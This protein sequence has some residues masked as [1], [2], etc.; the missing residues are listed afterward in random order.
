[1]ESQTI[2]SSVLTTGS[3]ASEVSFLFR[4]KRVSEIRSYESKIR[5]EAD[6]KTG[7]LRGLLGTRYRDLLQAADQMTEIR[8]ASTVNVRDALRQAAKSA[9]QLREHFLNQ[10]GD[11]VTSFN[12]VFEDLERRKSVQVIGSKLKFIVDSPEMLYSYL[13]SGDVYDAAKRY[14]LASDSYQQLQKT[15]DLEGIANSFAESRW[16]QVEVFKKQILSAAESKLVTPGMENIDYARYLASLIIMTDTET[17]IIGILNGMFASRTSWVDDDHHENKGDVPF[18]IRN[19]AKTIKTTIS[20]MAYMFWGEDLIME[21]LLHEVDENSVKKIQDLIQ[22]GQLQETSVSWIDSIS[23]WLNDHGKDILSDAKSSRELADTLRAL[24]DIFEGEEWSQNCQDAMNQPP[25][26]VFDLFK[27]YISKRADIVAH[28]CVHGAVNKVLVDIKTTWDEMGIGLHAG[29]LLWSTVSNQ[30]IVLKSDAESIL[31]R[32]DISRVLVSNGPVAGVIGTFETSLESAL[33]DVRVLTQG[34]PSVS[35]AFHTAVRSS[36]PKTLQDLE[37]RLNSIPDESIVD[38]DT[39][40]EL[41]DNYMEKA[42][43]IARGASALGQAKRVESAY[44]FSTQTNAKENKQES[45]SSASIHENVSSGM[46]EFQTAA[47]DLAHSGY[48]KWAKR[49][50]AKL[51]KQ[52]KDDLISHDI[53]QVPMGWS[54]THESNEDITSKIETSHAVFQHPTTA[55][56]A[57]TR[58]L[59]KVGCAMNRAGGFALPNE[60]IQFLQEEI[61]S[62]CNTAYKASLTYYTTPEDGTDNHSDVNTKKRESSDSAV[63]QMLFDIM[64]LRTLFEDQSSDEQGSLHD[65]ENEIRR[66]VDPIDLAAC[67][68]AFSHSVVRYT[69][70]TIILL[71]GLA[72]AREGK[73]TLTKRPNVVSAMSTS[74]NL[75]SLARQVPRFTY[76]PAP[77]PSTYTAGSGAV[78]LNAKAAMGR[79]RTEVAAADGP[80]RKK[81]TDTS[82]AGYASKVSESV[83]RFGRGFFESLTRNVG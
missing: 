50:C 30:S 33:E 40:E 57:M 28:D 12:N 43:F 45:A 44:S 70:R 21:K 61:T 35:H 19:I 4:T 31:E 22:N 20:C 25:S 36:L 2:H 37:E 77:M 42:L 14:T 76:L 27:P 16:K 34:V 51:E 79:L 53:L 78:G 23:S 62:A 58:F 24:H 8:E 67:K 29:K 59:M 49:L 55:S 75:V 65:L 56:T 13:E 52:L 69:S 54:S 26:F 18:Q 6:E 63:L 72:R 66:Q 71:G 32:D 7:S 82:V 39:N 47:T 83:G 3:V 64:S 60:S 11:E 41:Y 5:E 73:T 80:N 38:N 9:F 81:T 68:K 74:S 46:K 10:S 17:D 1:M 48:R 15:S